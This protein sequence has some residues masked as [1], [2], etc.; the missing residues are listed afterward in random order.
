[1]N[2]NDYDK[3]DIL[4]YMEESILID[5]NIEYPLNVSDKKSYQKSIDNYLIGKIRNIE[6]IEYND[7]VYNLEVDDDN[8][9]VANGVIVHNCAMT[10]VNMSQGWKSVGFK[11]MLA[12]YHQEN[13]REVIKNLVNSILNKDMRVGTDYTSFFN[14]K[15]NLNKNSAIGRI[16]GKIDVKNLF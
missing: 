1:V 16:G 5:K 3:N 10:L 8:S 4:S 9:Y 2:V 7:I 12:D 6:K 13:G 15:N 11:E 14:A